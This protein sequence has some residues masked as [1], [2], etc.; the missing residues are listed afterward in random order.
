MVPLVP[1][2]VMVLFAKKRA[3]NDR[4]ATKHIPTC[5]GMVLM[6]REPTLPVIEGMEGCIAL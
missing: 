4:L 1:T 2:A 5:D 6:N 3:A